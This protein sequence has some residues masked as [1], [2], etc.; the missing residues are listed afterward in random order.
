MARSDAVEQLRRVPIFA[1]LDRKDLETLSHFVREQTYEAGQSIVK[2]GDKGHGL[3]IIKEGKVSIRRGGKVIRQMGPGD[4]L[5]EIAILD[6]G[7]RTA[8]AVADAPTVCL[9]LSSW[10]TRPLLMQ[11]AGMSYAMLQEVVRRL[12]NATPVEMH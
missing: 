11:S 8:D 12:R 7:P 1:G 6:D 9:T 3:Y 4:F 10:E 5:G 2:E